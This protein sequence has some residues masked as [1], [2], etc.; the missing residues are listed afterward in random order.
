VLQHTGDSPFTSI[1]E[2]QQFLEGYRDYELY[3]CGRW[4]LFLKP[5]EEFI[6]WCGLKVHDEEWVDLGFRLMRAYWNQG[7]ATEAAWESLRIG[8]EVLGFR[9]IIGRAAVANKASLR[10]LENVG[11]RFWRWGTFERVPF[12]AFY[13]IEREDFMTNAHHYKQ[14]QDNSRG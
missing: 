6:G 3:G 2:A 14:E 9:Q 12:A 7:Y 5:Q 10:V 4:A 8:F 11:M 1:A 13:R